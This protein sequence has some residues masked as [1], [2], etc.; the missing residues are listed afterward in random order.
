MSP[1]FV[2]LIESGRSGS[3]EAAVRIASALGRQAEINLVDPKRSSAGRADLSTDLVHSAMGEF[4]ARR[5]RHLGF[6]LGIDEPYQHYQF[7]GRADLVAWD[8]ERRALLHIE[9]RTRFPDVQESAG[10]Y[11]AKRAY[12]GD[13]LAA[14]LGIARWGSETHVLAGLWSWEVLHALR[15]RP[16]TFRSLCPSTV[17]S[18]DGWW[19]GAPSDTGRTS[20]FVVLDPRARG[21]QQAFVG[22]DRALTVRAR[23]RGYAEAAEAIRLV[24]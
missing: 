2:Y 15:Q 12:L 3:A 8:L 17:D 18:F 21:R 24:A 19:A 20:V 22:L 6:A 5:L 13:A 10:S 11:N 16:E 14:R 4:E 23:Y 9:N 1:A 7:A